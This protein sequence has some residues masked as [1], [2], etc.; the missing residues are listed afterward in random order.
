MAAIFEEEWYLRRYPDVAEAIARGKVP[1]ALAH[2]ERHGRQ[3]GR[4][5]A[6]PPGTSTDR[7]AVRAKSYQS[8]PGEEGDSDS[9]QKLRCLRLPS[10]AGKS[11]LDV[12]CNEGFF[13]FEAMADGASRVLGIDSSSE[14]IAR[15]Q[16]R[17]AKGGMPAN[18]DFI[19]QTWDK[20]PSAKF[21][22]IFLLSALH[23]AEDQSAMIRKL[24]EHLTPKGLLV[25]ECGVVDEEQSALV[26]VPRA[27]DVV[28]FPTFGRMKEWLSPYAWKLM[29]A[30]VLQKGDPIPRKV[31]HIQPFRKEVILLL[32]SGHTGKTTFAR[33]LAKPGIP[34]IM[35]DDH[36]S[37]YHKRRLNDSKLAAIIRQHYDGQ[38]IDHL[39]RQIV[40]DGALDE[41]TDDIADALDAISA[42][43]TVVEGALGD[44]VVTRDRVAKRLECRGYYVWLC[45]RP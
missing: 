5:P 10:F 25:L 34:N 22:V 11:V 26:K 9:Q 28:S 15:A 6:S 20:I 35:I 17:K 23:Y 33:I 37:V 27:I 31:F 38:R 29:G 44:D 42:P 16:A 1:S 32:G 18:L 2:Y 7:A 12:G 13:C 45:S 30:S 8:F 43:I 40:A 19:C 39:Y 41:L 14:F 36:V 4:Q 24:I 3:E 21:D